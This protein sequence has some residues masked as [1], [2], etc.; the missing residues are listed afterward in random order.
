APDHELAAEAIAATQ[1]EA[2]ER[3]RARPDDVASLIY[4]S[5]TT[6]NRKGVMLTHKHLTALTASLAPLFPLK[7]RDRVRSVLPLHHTFE[8]TCGMLL[9]LSRGCRIVYL[10]ELNAER[11]DVGLNEGRITA[12]VGVPALWE[13]LERRMLAKVAERGEVASRIFDMAVEVNRNLGKNLGID[14]GRVL[15]G[16]VHEALGGHLRYL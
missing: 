8:L 6:G 4:T 3:R 10:D 9:P 14:T 11:L 15:F 16:P 2:A 1:R 13:M 5:G 12:M 7:S